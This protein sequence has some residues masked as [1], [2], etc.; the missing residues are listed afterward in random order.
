MMSK[1]KLFFRSKTFVLIVLLFV[2]VMFFAVLSKGSYFSLTNL[3]NVLNSMVLY[4]LLAIGVGIIIIT[5]EIDLSIGHV[6]SACGVLMAVLSG[7]YYM[8]WYITIVFALILGVLL[9]LLNAVLINELDF[10]SFIV[11]LAIGQFVA[12]G[13]A[14]IICGGKI[15]QIYDETLVYIGNGRIYN[16]IPVAIIISLLA[17]IVYGIILAK[18][19][20]GRSVYLCGGNKEA[21]RL[22]GLNPKKISY[23]L[24]AN[25]G[26]LGALAGIVFMGRLKAGDVSGTNDYTFTAITAAIL[27]GISFGGGSGSMFGCFIG[28]LVMQSFTN[29]LMVM[30][31]NTHWQIVASGVLLFIALVFDY[32]SA[33][34]AAKPKTGTREKA[35]S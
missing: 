18:T 11:T 9:G 23:I 14:L 13:L 31:V 27:G 21:A 12:K 10:P 30:R 35:V 19:K 1:T 33:R 17:V 8:P 29:G 5:G 20:F 32:I 34:N 3:R 4:L 15:I 16:I 2:I 22:A 7:S 25:S 26:F 6:G 24:Y 28:L